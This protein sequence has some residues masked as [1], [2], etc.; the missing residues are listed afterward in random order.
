MVDDKMNFQDVRFTIKYDGTLFFKNM[1]I[2]KLL[3]LTLSNIEMRTK[4]TSLYS[5]PKYLDIETNNTCN[6]RCPSCPTIIHTSKRDKKNMSFREF[7]SITEQVKDYI[8]TV[9]FGLNGEPFLNPEIFK[10]IDYLNNNRIGS[11]VQSNFN[12]TFDVKKIIDHP[13]QILVVALDGTTDYTY[14]KYRAGGDFNKVIP[15]IRKLIRIKKERR[16]KYP[17]IFWQFIIMK[18]NE[19]QV[20]DAIKMSKNMGF[21]GIT[22]S[23]PFIPLA[24]NWFF[25]ENNSNV[26]RNSNEFSPSKKVQFSTKMLACKQLY[27]GMSI[28]V[29]GTI[30]PCCRVREKGLD[31]GNAF[32]TPLKDIWNNER[33]Q[34]FRKNLAKQ[35]GKQRCD[36]C[37][38]LYYA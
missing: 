38:R 25:D 29:D 18:H 30:I 22:F 4:R 19:Y 7:K 10:M 16:K 12:L 2:K 31:F 1:T 14:S 21:D 27:Q 13:P 32:K 28:L 5:Y 37:L 11:V 24:D 8:F 17:L 33:F 36:N 35:D 23:V 9:Y 20:N 6:L 3:N 26:E 34:T 15:D